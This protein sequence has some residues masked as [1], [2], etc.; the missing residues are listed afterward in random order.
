MV[1]CSIFAMHEIAVLSNREGGRCVE[2]DIAESE[3][4]GVEVESGGLLV[5]LN[6]SEVQKSVAM[7]IQLEAM[8][9]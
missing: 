1:G 9:S 7:L 5:Q 4:G 3:V 2:G 8:R 6:A